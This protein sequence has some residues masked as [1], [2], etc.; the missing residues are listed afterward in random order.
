MTALPPAM[1]LGPGFL[2]A[3]ARPV[4]VRASASFGAGE[5]AAVFPALS[6]LAAGLR[7][8]GIAAGF[9]GYE[10]AMGL[11]PGLVLP[12][13]P[14]HE[15]RAAPLAS[16][17]L[18]EGWETA[19]PP[20]VADDIAAARLP[21]EGADAYKGKLARIV[22]AIGEGDLFQA[23]LSRRLSASLPKDASGEA[24]FARLMSG[25]DAPFAARIAGEGWEVLSASPELFLRVEDGVALAE[26]I[27]GTRGRGATPEADAALAAALE[28]DEKDRAEN[29]M[30]ADLMRN[31]LSKVARDHGVSVPKLCELR[32]L[33]RVHHLV[34]QVRAALRDDQGPAEAAAACYPC[35]SIT[36]APKLA[37][38][39][40]I[41]RL[42]GE[43][44][45]PYCG[46]VFCVPHDG[47]AVFSVAIR[48]GL[49][50]RGKETAR[51]DVRAGGGVTIL[52]DPEAEWAE[53]V[54]KAYPFSLMTGLS[55][56]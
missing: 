11:E 27:K 29:V 22:S 6:R 9:I 24:L 38:M 40:L 47:P 16:F 30:I 15:G 21:G 7:P 17:A 3:W 10:A 44:R 28:A 5:A 14:P 51:L 46:T 56:A 48:T 12:E 13:P 4:G 42:E 55:G 1:L 33:P 53:T 52:S 18:F 23:N 36:G 45:G 41:A 49:L 8:G 35:G 37:A 50:L 39:Q 32:T 34:S 25:T 20:S 26:P 2:G 19:T 43:G 31:D 54:D